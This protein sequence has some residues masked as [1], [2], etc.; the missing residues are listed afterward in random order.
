[1]EWTNILIV[2]FNL[3]ETTNN[4]PPYNLIQVNNV[5]S[6]LEIALAG[7]KKEEVNVFTEYGKLFVEGQKSDTESD[8]TFVHK[9]L[10]QRSFK[11]VWTL[12]DDTEVRE[13]TFEDGLLVIRLKKIVP[14]HHN[15]KITY[16]YFRISLPQGGN[17]QKPVD[18][19]LFYWYNTNR[20]GVKMTVKL[21][22]LKSGEDL[23]AD[24]QEMVFGEDEEK[25]VVGYYLTNLVL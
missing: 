17:W 4:Y 3:H 16:K 7:F 13:V 18:T 2:Y 10:A 25:R 6:H 15:E 8:R 23:I 9:G 19:S 20:Y 1:L 21:L 14:E 22:L 12:S 24:V 5:E 11:R